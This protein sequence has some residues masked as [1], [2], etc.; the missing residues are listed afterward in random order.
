MR[1]RKFHQEQ[2]V[3]QRVTPDLERP[4]TLKETVSASGRR[5]DIPI[6]IGYLR[7]SDTVEARDSSPK[8]D[9]RRNW[10]VMK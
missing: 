4:L 8:T 1:C 3:H 10:T 6:Y 2:T 7:Y 5:A 9:I